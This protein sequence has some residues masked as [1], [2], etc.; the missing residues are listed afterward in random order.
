MHQ[1][2]SVELFKITSS[3]FIRILVLYFGFL[4]SFTYSLQYT[5]HGH[6]S[7]SARLILQ[8]SS[9]FYIFFD[10]SYGQSK[11]NVK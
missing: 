10:L 2:A 9:P 6:A 7:L 11:K 8:R 3:Q 1:I 5:I 4:L